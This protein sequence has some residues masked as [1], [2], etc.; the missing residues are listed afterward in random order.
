[1]GTKIS[2]PVLQV[3]LSPRQLHA[4]AQASWQ[5]SAVLR[6]GRPVRI[7]DLDL[8]EGGRIGVSP[9]GDASG[10]VLLLFVSHFDGELLVAQA[11]RPQPSPAA[12]E[13]DLGDDVDA[14]TP[15]GRAVLLHRLGF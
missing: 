1:M 15:A 13:P 5:G 7:S 3:P 11:S 10:K 12:A 6:N 14:T 9:S 4:G 8:S 2:R